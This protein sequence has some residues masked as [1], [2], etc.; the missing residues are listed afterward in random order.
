MYENR[1]NGGVYVWMSEG[2]I[3]SSFFS[4]LICMKERQVGDCLTVRTWHRVDKVNAMQLYWQAKK[5]W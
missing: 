2:D 5:R 1:R 3:D 4:C